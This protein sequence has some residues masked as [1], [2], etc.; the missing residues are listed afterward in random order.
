MTAFYR[1][2]EHD[3]PAAAPMF[4]ISR[5]SLWLGLPFSLLPLAYPIAVL[6]VLTRRHVVAAFRGQAMPRELPDGDRP[7]RRGEPSPDAFTS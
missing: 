1:Q 3:F 7:E 4:A 5:A 6:V 2:L